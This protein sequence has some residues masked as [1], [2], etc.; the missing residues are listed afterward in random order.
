MNNELLCFTRF[1]G[2]VVTLD[3]SE[4]LTRSEDLAC[5]CPQEMVKILR[6][7]RGLI[8]QQRTCLLN[9]PSGVVVHTWLTGE[10]LQLEQTVARILGELLQREGIL[11]E[12]FRFS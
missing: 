3:V 2:E 12:D 7:V 6:A 1:N 4:I 10:G 8:D 11:G 5:S 9:N